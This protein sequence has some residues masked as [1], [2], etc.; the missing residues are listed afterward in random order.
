MYIVQGV[1]G[2]MEDPLRELISRLRTIKKS[3]CKHILCL[4]LFMRYNEFCVYATPV[5]NI[6]TLK[7][8]IE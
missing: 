8:R 6:E 7:N 3:S 4:S 2:H 5:E 1:T